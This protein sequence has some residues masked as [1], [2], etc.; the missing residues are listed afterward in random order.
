MLDIR[1]GLHFTWTDVE[2]WIDLGLITPEQALAIRRQLETERPAPSPVP[3]RQ[4]QRQG[5]NLI[6]VAYYFGGFM[7]LLAYTFFMGMRWE[8]M[9]NDMR[10]GLTVATMGLLWAVGTVLR[11]YGFP[12]AGG[13]L[14]F[15]GTGLVPLAAFTLAD[16]LG[17]WPSQPTWDNPNYDDYYT[18]VRP[19]WIYLEAVSLLAAVIVTWRIRFPLVTLLIAFWGWYLS[20]DLARWATQNPFG[21]FDDTEQIVSIAVGVAM[22]LV[23]LFLQRRTREDYSRWFYLF[24]HLIILGN[25]GALTYEKEGILSLVFILTYLGFVV[26]SVS[27]Q[28]PVFLVFGALGCYGYVSYL[29]FRTFSGAVGFPIAMAF[30]GLV[31]VLTAVAY[32]KYVRAWLEQRL[33]RQ[34]LP[35]E[36]AV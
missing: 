22:L 26:A 35:A 18:T 16:L 15:A 23:G 6:T 1:D 2:R 25:L 24:G 5:L 11:R 20:M 7:I 8:S 3:A 36:Q 34:A 31:V 10:F 33:S 30:I 32:Q 28:R 29:A 19:Y 12:T 21:S 9:G 13:L 14:I 17:L 27:L 4:E